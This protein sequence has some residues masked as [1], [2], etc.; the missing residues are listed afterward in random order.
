MLSSF[1][2]KLDDLSTVPHDNLEKLGSSADVEIER[3]FGI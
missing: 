1:R 3:L 2:G